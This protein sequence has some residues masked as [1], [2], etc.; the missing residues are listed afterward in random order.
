MKP[1]ATKIKKKL[2]FDEM[3]K[4]LENK[5]I[6][7]NVINKD[8][9]RKILEE[10]NYYYKISAYRKNYAKNHLDKYVNLEFAYL[11]DLSTIDMRIRYL[12]I[13]MCLD[14]EHALKVRILRDITNKPHEDGYEIVTKFLSVERLSAED[15]MPGGRSRDHY[16]REL[17]DRH[18]DNPPVWVLLEAM[19]FGRFSQFVEFYMS[20]YRKNNSYFRDIAQVIRYVKNIRNAAAHNH[21]LIMDIA[22]P[23]NDRN[24][25]VIVNFIQGITTISKNTRNNKLRNRK[26]HDLVALLYT[27][28]RYIKSDGMKMHR[29]KDIEEILR[30]AKRNP[31]FY[32]KNNGIT[33]TYDFFC[34]IID[35]IKK[36][37]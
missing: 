23:R 36:D 6:D 22:E 21:P 18:I 31:S 14:I 10:T 3:V 34:K 35:F 30:R 37:A 7:F 15:C 16:G 4:H 17:Y 27:Y 24:S 19:T 2:S 11:Y 33:S 5:G 8:E 32:K 25:R 26:I 29:Y 12:A 13:Q 28:N 1:S 20:E 9:A